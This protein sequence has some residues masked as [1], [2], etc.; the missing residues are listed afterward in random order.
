MLWLNGSIACSPGI[1]DELARDAGMQGSAQSKAG[2]DPGGRGSDMPPEPMSV[3]AG[4][5][6]QG[7]AGDVGGPVQTPASGGAGAAGTSQ[8]GRAAAAVGGQSGA[9]GRPGA[10]GGGAGAGGK[11]AAAG[12]GAGSAAGPAAGSGGGEPAQ[13]CTPPSAE[14]ARCDTYPQCG[15]ASGENCTWFYGPDQTQ[16]ACIAEGSVD[17]Y[18]RCESDRDCKRGYGC[19]DRACKRY[20]ETS[21]DTSCEGVAAECRQIYRSSTPVS[22]AYFCSRSC[23]P[24][25]PKREDAEWDACGADLS[26][27]MRKGRNG[28]DWITDCARAGTGQSLVACKTDA[29]CAPG[30]GCLPLPAPDM[31]SVCRAWCR[32]D[33]DDCAQNETCARFSTA[34]YLHG[35]E[36]GSCV[37]YCNPARP[38]LN[39]AVWT[40]CPDNYACYTNDSRQ[41]SCSPVSSAGGTQG[42][43]CVDATG[44]QQVGLCAPGFVC[45]VTSSSSYQ[46]TRRCEL[47]ATSNDCSVG[48]CRPYEPAR[49]AKDRQIGYCATDEIP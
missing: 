36:M 17:A 4:V 9:A 45:R 24:V 34:V 11:P 42:S 20:C 39:D 46:C 29:D 15:C 37:G 28:S 35:V 13:S 12:G 6:S 40:A 38:M 16:L 1:F 5:G 22:A 41:S 7:T 32:L 26:C 33:A 10:S 23:D 25:H 19:L 14:G 8:G 18:Q 31:Q 43:P 27:I 44:Q 3:T 30:L 47:D 49:Y 2:A 21:G 48:T